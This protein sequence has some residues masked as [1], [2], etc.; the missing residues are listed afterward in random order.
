MLGAAVVFLV[1]E[2]SKV[3]SG[4]EGVIEVERTTPATN[5]RLQDFQRLHFRYAETGINTYRYVGQADAVAQS[6]EMADLAARLAAL[7][8]RQS[9][10]GSLPASVAFHG[11]H[12]VS[13]ARR[14]RSGRLGELAGQHRG[15]Q[16][17]TGCAPG[18]A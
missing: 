7:E 4:C 1:P 10:G 3:P 17:P 18:S 11:V 8:V 9:F 13:L 2:R 16:A 14:T 6:G 12:G 5:S 15:G